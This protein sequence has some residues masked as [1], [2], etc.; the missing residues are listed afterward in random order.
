MSDGEHVLAACTCCNM[1]AWIDY[2][3]LSYTIT[4]RNPCITAFSFF[5]PI[6]K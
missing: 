2:H 3:L 4:N 1:S 6:C 5:L